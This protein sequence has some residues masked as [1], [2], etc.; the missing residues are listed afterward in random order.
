MDTVDDL[1]S[2]D[3]TRLGEIEPNKLA[4]STGI[5]VVH[6]LGISKSLKNRTV[7]NVNKWSLIIVSTERNNYYN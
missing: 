4:K 7:R 5:V 3:V 6:S 2:L 1:A